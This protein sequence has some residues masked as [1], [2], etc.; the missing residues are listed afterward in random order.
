MEITNSFKQKFDYGPLGQQFTPPYCYEFAGKK[1]QFKFEEYTASACFTDREHMV[2]QGKTEEQ[3]T[4]YWCLKLNND[5]YMICFGLTPEKCVTLIIDMVSGLI[6]LDETSFD[7]EHRPYKSALDF[8]IILLPGR[9]IP[10]ERHCFTKELA[11][12]TLKWIF[13]DTYWHRHVYGEEECELSSNLEF[14]KGKGPYRAVRIS[15]AVYYNIAGDDRES[16]CELM[17]L[18]NMTLVARSVIWGNNGKAIPMGA[19][20][21]FDDG[22]SEFVDLVFPE[23]DK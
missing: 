3:E 10:A 19:V 5:T 21:K 1:L 4:A 14:V 11:G 2:W 6:T 13:C 12:N 9:E 15:D 7:D 20:G 22:T 17:N 18:K 8:G 23:A 16:Y